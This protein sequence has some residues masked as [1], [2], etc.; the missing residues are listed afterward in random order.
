MNSKFDE[1]KLE[2][3]VLFF[4]G[5]GGVGK[6]SI[7]CASAINLSKQGKKILLVS[8]DP[9]SNLQDV[10]ETEINEDISV[11]KIY[12]NLSLINLDPK[13]AAE[14]YRERAVAPYRGVLPKTA[15]E[16]MLEQLSGS[17]T[18]EIASFNQFTDLL[19][20]ADM[21]D[22]YDHII[23]DTAPTGHTLRM[24]QLPSAWS[25][26]IETS[27]HGA[28][29]LGQLS[30]LEKDKSKYFDAV[31]ILTNPDETTLVLVSRPEK[32]AL[33][34]SSRASQELHDIGMKSQMLIINGIVP[35]LEDNHMQELRLNQ[36]E[37]LLEFE[38]FLDLMQI[39]EVDLKPKS[40]YTAKTLERLFNGN[41][42][43]EAVLETEVVSALMLKDLVDSIEEEDKRVI[44]TMGKGGVGKTTVASALALELSQRGHSVILTTTDPANHLQY[45]ISEND[46]LKVIAID[47]K[48]VLEAYRKEVLDAAQNLSN[49][50][51]LDYIEEDLRSPC[52]QE[53]AVFKEFAKIVD[54]SDDAIVIID[55]APTGHTLLL[56]ESSESHHQEMKRNFVETENEVSRLIPKLRDSQQTEVII[57][58]LPEATPFY[59]AQRL[60]EDLNRAQILCNWWVINNSIINQ[61]NIS[62]F[63][64]SKQNDEVQWIQKIVSKPD[65]KVA[66]VGKM[67]KEINSKTIKELTN[68][69]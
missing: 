38:M 60:E 17:C 6:T 65:R 12:P 42:D 53:I 25:S 2:T 59:E 24:L 51:D 64:Q 3:Q 68:G 31:D 56:F 43:Y 7:A 14:L 35:F 36:H 40:I 37:I 48:N 21:R 61:E 28:S 50:A 29:C 5:K 39:Y 44:F 23:F 47:E 54:R 11:S 45:S 57:V 1:S 67:N 9:A 20:D 66:I 10:F 13:R 16:N 41:H 8:T 15:I 63:L 55:T 27:T 49:N 69:K 33:I 22:T 32:T 4:T 34:E 18:T 30:G 62:A 46:N 26:F 58:T 19:T 52:T